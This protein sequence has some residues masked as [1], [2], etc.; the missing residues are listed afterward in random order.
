MLCI[1]T[2]VRNFTLEN[3]KCS[4]IWKAHL[5]TYS[6]SPQ[7]IYRTQ[8]ILCLLCFAFQEC[9]KVYINLVELSI[10]ISQKVLIKKQQLRQYFLL[11]GLE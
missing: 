2:M 5:N 4:N 7:L 10:L 11:R 3:G 6:I 1:C 9:Q 8:E